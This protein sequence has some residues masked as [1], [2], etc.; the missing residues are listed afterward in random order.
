MSNITDKVYD[1][2]ISNNLIS[3]DDNILVALSGGADS[4]FLLIC[5]NSLK[6]KLG[7]SLSACHLNHLIRGKEADG[8]EQFCFELCKRLSIDFYSKKADIPS[9][10]K[11]TKMS[12]EEAGRCERYKYFNELSKKIG[13]NK[14][15]VAHNKNDC[16]ET[17]FIN[18]IRGCSLNG[19][20]SIKPVNNNI[21]R[22]ILSIERS[23][24]EIYLNKNG[25][26]FCT[27]S[28][29]SENIYTRNK[30]RNEIIPLLRQIN[31]SLIDTIFNN[32]SLY[33]Q[34]DE[35]L[36][37]YAKSLD[38]V[39]YFDNYVKI[40]C[41]KLYALDKA[42]QKRIIL[43]AI[44]YLLGDLR[45]F[46]AKHINLILDIKNSGKVLMM[47]RNIK[48]Y[49]DFNE[50]TISKNN[51]DFDGFFINN[52]EIN[53]NIYVN[54]WYIK[55][56]IVKQ[57]DNKSENTLYVDY[58]KLK[59][60]TITLRSK[61]ENDKIKLFGLNGSKKIKQLFTELKIPSRNRNNVPIILDGDEI[62]CVVPYRISELYKIDDNTNEILRIQFFKEKNNG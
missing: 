44:E 48:I 32:I 11:E 30:I 59:N 45:N 35:F 24:I 34:D 54:D 15:A 57:Y 29:N 16:V 55:L 40:S 17:L 4:V 58:G 18:L 53:K 46:E 41:D 5:L 19:L 49:Y 13:F 42:V 20:C 33:R 12:E 6:E 60:K 62:V 47:P 26:N 14:I 9:I 51:I 37:N 61:K 3:S 39:T 7:I 31:P 38:A 43:N 21:I 2:I 25:I 23:E 50:I 28:T 8:D 52:I 27:D 1:Y 36:K 22:P 10:S 56:D